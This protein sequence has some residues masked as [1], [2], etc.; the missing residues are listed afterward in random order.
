M[1]CVNDQL[2]RGIMGQQKRAKD[3]EFDEIARRI[4]TEVD[5]RGRG[6][7]IGPRT[8]TCLYL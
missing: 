3:L 2:N 4:A 6:T 5:G 7:K 1:A 8:A